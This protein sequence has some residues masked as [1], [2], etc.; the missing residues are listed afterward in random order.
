M[1]LFS[2]VLLWL[3]A[4][5]LLASVLRRFRLWPGLLVAAG[6]ALLAWRL[7]QTPTADSVRWLGQ[8]IDPSQETVLLGFRFSLDDPVRTPLLL[9]LA[10]GSVMALAGGWAGA[11]RVLFP[12][13][14]LITA[15]AYLA[16]AS[17]PLLWA[18]FWLVLAAILIAFPAQGAQP[19]RA[20]GALRT[21]VAPILALPFFLMAAW[22]FHQTTPDA[23][24][25]GLWTNAWRALVIGVGILLTPVPLHGWIVALGEDSPPFAAAWIVGLWQITVYML[26]R[27]IL[28]AYPSLAD[29]ADPARLLP[30]LALIQ[31]T[32]AAV[33]AFGSQRLGQFWGYLLLWD[34]GA[35]FLLWSMTGE[36]GTQSMLWLLLA[37]LLVLCL[38]A[39]GLQSIQERYQANPPYHRLQGASQRFPLA[40]ASVLGG[41]LF[42]VGWPLGALF[43]IRV[44]T[45]QLAQLY[46]PKLFLGLMVAVLVMILAIIRLQ[47]AFFQPL[48][49]SHLRREPAHLLWLIVP[50]F[51]INILLSIHPGLLEPLTLQLAD[52][53]TRF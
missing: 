5:A 17:A 27:H 12:A 43:P 50:L 1:S 33:F 52:W 3:L 19:R 14:P 20:R 4:L 13:I 25:I 23:D 10:W 51:A 53:L 24:N 6:L 30:W 7:W 37:R 21:L 42:I 22:V 38:I 16:L 47:R 40:T 41:A 39:V 15:A 2:A 8:W 49:D 46:A 48:T 18:P 26:V 9:L 44:A 28:L 45:M 32:W 34:Y 29:Y 35:T 11:D 36:L 31:M